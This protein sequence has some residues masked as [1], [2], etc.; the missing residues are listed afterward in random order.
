MQPRPTSWLHN[1]E[2]ACYGEVVSHPTTNGLTPEI[3]G[4]P[5]IH[6]HHLEY[7][8]AGQVSQPAKAQLRWSP[9]HS[10]SPKQ[11]GRHLVCGAQRRVTLRWGAPEHDCTTAETDV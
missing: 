6:A 5:K 10:P 11:R 3:Q 1:P 8:H 7:G 9:K 2:T 4:S